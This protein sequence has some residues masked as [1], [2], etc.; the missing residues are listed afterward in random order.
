MHHG[1]FVISIDGQAV[2]ISNQDKNYMKMQVCSYQILL[3]KSKFNK[4]FWRK[5]SSQVFVIVIGSISLILIPAASCQLYYC[6]PPSCLLPVQCTLVFTF[7]IALLI[8][9][10]L[11]LHRPPSC[12]LPVQVVG[13]GDWLLRY[14]L[15]VHVL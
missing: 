8:L 12:L 15:Y 7:A 1:L 6:K 13:L 11:K 2:S 4:F 9:M 5:H 10:F 14:L 3:L